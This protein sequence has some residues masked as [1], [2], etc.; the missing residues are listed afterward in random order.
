MRSVRSA[1]AFIKTI[2]FLGAVVAFPAV[3]ARRL[4]RAPENLV[5][6]IE[7]FALSK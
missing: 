5:D 7:K 6:A 1:P 3:V 2:L 4:T